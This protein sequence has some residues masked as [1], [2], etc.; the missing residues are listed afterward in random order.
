MGLTEEMKTIYIETAR[1]LKGSERR[2][3]MARVV[4]ELGW[5]GQSLAARALGWCRD[6]IRKGIREVDSG[7]R[8]EDNFAARGR[9]KAEEKLPNLL[10]DIEAIVDGQS[11]TDTTFN[12]NRLYTRMSAAEVRQ[13]LI[14][15][16]GYQDSELPTEETIRVKLNALGYR[17]RAVRKNRPQKGS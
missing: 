5:G 17:L 1:A 6:T 9:K 15:Q 2:V 14:L 16:K 8:I 7:E 13:Q 10:T 3:F 4:K 12:S 11:Q